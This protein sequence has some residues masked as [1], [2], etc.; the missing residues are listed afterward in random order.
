[1]A[2]LLASQSCPLP[3]HEPY[4]SE[5]VVERNRIEDM[6]QVRELEES[7]RQVVQSPEAART[8]TPFDRGLLLVPAGAEGSGPCE[9]R[10]I[11][12]N[13]DLFGDDEREKGASSCR[14]G[15]E[16]SQSAAKLREGEGVAKGAMDWQELEQQERSAETA[17]PQQEAPDAVSSSDA[18]LREKVVRST[19]TQRT[20]THGRCRRFATYS[21][22]STRTPRI[23]SMKWS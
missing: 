1:V 6:R 4:L 8:A 23:R 9:S 17:K 5:E 2:V 7:R 21:K 19:P 20:F 12:G 13:H 15:N 22:R 3:Q 18:E 14:E 16:P 10:C 11:S